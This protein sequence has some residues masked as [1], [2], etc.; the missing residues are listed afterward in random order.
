[1]HGARKAPRGPRR[2]SFPLRLP[3]RAVLAGRG[4][5]GAQGRPLQGGV[6]G[7]TMASAGAA[8]LQVCSQV[9]GVEQGLL[10]PTHI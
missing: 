10:G 2:G 6:T 5:G 7:P 8:P 3:A 4:V 1:M 9:R